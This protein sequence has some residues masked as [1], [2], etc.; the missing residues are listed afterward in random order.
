MKIKKI[1][2]ASLSLGLVLSAGTVA[3]ATDTASV[4]SQQTIETGEQTASTQASNT[5]DKLGAE[6][7]TRVIGGE[8]ADNTTTTNADNK[9]GEKLGAE[10][11]IRVI[12][13]ENAGNTANTNADD[14]DDEKLGAERGTRVIGGENKDNADN[15]NADNKDGE[16]LGG[17]RGTRVIGGENKETANQADGTPVGD[18]NEVT[19]GP[20]GQGVEST[21]KVEKVKMTADSDDSG[22]REGG[23]N[24]KTGI[25]TTSAGLV[26]ASAAAA[27]TAS[28]KYR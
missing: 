28:K 9:D 5:D 18:N 25:A 27:Y 17:E 16:K 2:A 19:S 7:G 24:P 26:L 10:R 6:K 22:N 11:G 15:A 23:S 12:G 4:R 21:A 1:L 14:K 13:G 20:K 3:E 8:N